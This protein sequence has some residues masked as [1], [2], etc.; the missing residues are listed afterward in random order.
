MG[1]DPL[2][3][4]TENISWSSYTYV[5]G[6]P[7][8]TIDPDGRSGETVNDEYRAIHKSD[9]TVEYEWMSS[10][11][12]NEMDIIHHTDEYAVPDKR[13]REWIEAV[14][15][16]WGGLGERYKPGVWLSPLAKGTATVTD[17]PIEWVIDLPKALAAK[18]AM[19][20]LSL[21]KKVATKESRVFWSGGVKAMNAAADYAKANGMKTLE[22]TRAGQNLAN[23][24]EGMPWSEAGP[25][26][27]RLSAV[28]AKGA[29]GTVHVFHNANGVR[30][31]SVWTTVEYP[32]LKQNGVEIVYH[33]V[34]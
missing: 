27:Q 7:V 14:E 25:M 23:L 19:L 21:T 17:S 11:G 9:G 32:I 16:P 28:Y 15:N 6:N 20:V 13:H 29:K 5:W 26:W 8:L 24:T 3:G 2:G 18:G 34:H 10:E 1:V 22:M 12:G 4:S 30:L 33:L 31:E